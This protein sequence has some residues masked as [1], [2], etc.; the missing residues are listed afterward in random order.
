[1][2]AVTANHLAVQQGSLNINDFEQLRQQ[3]WQQLTL[4]PSLESVFFGNDSGEEIGYGRFQGEEALKKVE[5]VT[6]ENLSIGTPYLAIHR[7][8]DPGKRKY[9]LADS[10]GNPRQLLYTFP[11]DNR[12]TLW[13]RTAKAFK[14]QTWS[15]I[16]VYKVIPL[17]GI[18]AVT[19]IYNEAGKW[20]GALV[21]SFTLSSISTFLAQ[22][23]FSPSGQVFIMERSG[24]LVATSTQ[25]RLLVKPAQGKPEQLLAVNSQDT[26]TRDIARQLTQKFGN[27]HTLRNTQQLSLVSNRE[28]QFVR[29]TPYQDKYGL[30]WLVVVVVPESDFMEQIHANTHTT[31]LLCIVALIGSTGIGI[32]TAGWITKPI[33]RLNAVAKDIAK[34]QWDNPVELER[35]DEVGQLAHSFNTMV[36]QRQ[37]A[38]ELL[39]HYNRTLEAQVAERTA[40]LVKAND[41]LRVEIA[42]RELIEGKLYSSTQQVRTIF[43]SI[44]DIVLIIDVHRSIQI[45]PTKTLGSYTCDTN[46]LNRIVEQFFQEDTEENWF[47]KVQ[48]VLEI[49]QNVNFDYS[50]SI[51]NQEIW[52]TACI[53]PLPDNSVVWVARDISDRKLAEQALQASQARFAGIL[54]IANDAIITVDASQRITLFNQG[55]EKIFGYRLD[56]VLGQPLDLLLP[57]RIREIHHQHI[58]SFSNSVG[59]ARPMGERSEIS[60]CRK[61]GTEFPAEASISKLEINGEKYFT[62]IL[63]DISDRKQAEKALIE[64]EERYRSVITAMSEGVVLQQANG[65]IIAHNESAKRILDLTPDRMMGR[66]SVDLDWRTIQEDGS[67]F[68]GDSHPAMVTLQT[69]QPQFNVVMG[70]CKSDATKTW[71]TINSQPLFHPGEALPYAVVTSFADITER[72]LAEEA[73]R[74]YERMVSA[75]ADAMVL[76]DRNYI[77]QVANQTYLAWHK[78]HYEEIIGHSISEIMGADVFAN[79]MKERLDRALAGETVAWQTWVEL[80]AGRRFVSVT[81]SPYFE[82]DNTISGLVASISDITELK[83]TEERLRQTNQEMQAIFAAFPDILFRLAADGTILDYKTKNDDNLYTSPETLLGK[84]V[85]DVLP[86]PVG[87]NI[88]AAVRRVLETDSP[89][90]LEYSIPMPEGEQYFEARMVRFHEN[91]VIAVTRNISDR[92]R[93]EDSLR[94]SEEQLQL[95]LEGSGDG[96]WDWN[97][98]TGETYLSPRYLEMLGYEADE[99]SPDLSTWER[100]IH[101][102]DR[103]W[104]MEILNAHLANSSVPYNFDYRLLT[105]S[106]EWKWI[107]NYGKVAARDPNGTPLRM[108]GT[109]RDV[110]DKKRAEQQ[111]Q[112][113]EALLRSMTD[114]SPLAFY[115]V[116]NR[117]DAILYFNHRFCE[118]WGI[119]HL[120]ARLQQGVLKNNDILPDCIPALKDVEA[121][122]E[123]CKPLQ[124][125]ENRIVIEDE[126]P[127]VDGRTIRRFSAQIRD[128]NDRY[129]GRLY[130]FEDITERKQSQVTLQHAVISAETANRAKSTF[131][132]NMSHELRTPLNGILGYAQILQRSKD[133]TPQQKEGLGIIQ[134]CGEHLL[135]LINDILDLSKIEAD[136]LELYPDDFNLPLFLQGIVEIFRLKAAQ[137][138]IDFTDVA[139][140]QLP[141][142]V[143]ADEKR[144]RQILMNLLSN[145]VKFTDSGSVTFKVEVIQ[146][147]SLTVGNWEHEQFPIPNSPFPIFRIRFYVEDTG[148]GINPEHL[149]K[150]FLPFEQ[151]RASSHYAEGT[152]LGLAITQK[153][154]GLM[155][156]QIWVE[157][158][159]N[160]GSKFW[161][162]L[163]LPVVS[164]AIESILIQSTHTIV[165]YQGKKRKILVVDDRWEN[166]AVLI[167]LLEPLGFELA[168]AANGQEGLEKAL[169]V[170]PDLIL[171][172]LVMSVMDGY[173]MTRQL[174]QFPSFQTTTIIAISANVFEADRIQSLESGCNDF[175]SKPLQT[176]EL[177]DKIKSYLNLTWIY[178]QPETGDGKGLSTGIVDATALQMVIPPPEELLTLSQAA[179]I[180]DISGVEQEILRL[181]QL[182]PD[183]HSFVTKLMKL[184]QEFE[185]EEIVNLVDRYL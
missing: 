133:S 44:S 160:V 127:F 156:S 173:E 53:S 107:A 15:P 81:Y 122:A 26:R 147:E 98:Q 145:A 22:L 30:D 6:G 57:T 125:E 54:E 168:K 32:L 69:G 164:Y 100:L 86:A 155:D 142:I 105:K 67:P 158:I 114:T 68:P 172:D 21:S 41:Q 64:S 178:D 124:S 115:V 180:G 46:V 141:R 120:E 154:I 175:L 139:S 116:D 123:S 33:L 132:A 134:Q 138:S 58:T 94:E 157:S 184:A 183:Y 55:A 144:L 47:A 56:E 77:Y 104:V 42:E 43:E 48:Q 75:T 45:I 119:E 7:S 153:L 106:G 136:K 176:E 5:Q 19:P 171:A 59:K 143:R 10:K 111:L 118:I 72:K 182:N 60:G 91:E 103:A 52:F 39:A 174:R 179:L 31:I 108:T 128:T 148:I 80:A 13:Y 152:G 163:N 74:R 4:N 16:S 23:D 49:Q 71:I 151:V 181:E 38:E 61:D 28:G 62:T 165:G 34:G 101:P 14:Q 121:F 8:T 131:L 89:V 102:D 83:Q 3:F 110:S 76:V 135:T 87:Q 169:E 35:T 109:H 126:I 1:Q 149:G 84:K 90:S 70:I 18:F 150:I 37:Q 159:P 177:L 79:L 9:Y 73:L 66:T 24:K 51:N 95:A 117:T 99:L 36:V 170:Q 2:N 11:I 96:F 20:R 146:D 17:L 130:I 167:N 27:F 29:V 137:K 162:D 12:T 112:W 78:K 113:K 161:F 140:H 166:C 85:Q 97:V 50:L 92:K 40:E 82:T 63:R 93:A 185:Y 65:A 88:Q 25:E 129:F